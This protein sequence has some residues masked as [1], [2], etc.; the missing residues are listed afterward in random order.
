MPKIK[1]VQVVALGTEATSLVANFFGI[2]PP[3]DSRTNDL[4]RTTDKS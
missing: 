1:G 4:M 3:V 2:V